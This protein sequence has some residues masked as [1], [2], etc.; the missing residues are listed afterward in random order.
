MNTAIAALMTMVNEFAAHGCSKGDVEQLLLLLSP[1]AP[2]MVE[3]LWENLGFA[4]KYGKMACQMPWP[5]HD[6]RTRARPWTPRWSW[7]CRSAA[8]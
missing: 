4:A 7:P 5:A 6:E 3:E 2:H 1:F 8:S